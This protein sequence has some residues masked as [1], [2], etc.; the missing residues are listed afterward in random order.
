MTKCNEESWTGSWSRRTLV[1]NWWNVNK[2]CRLVI[3]VS[4]R[5]VIIVSML[6]SLF[7]GYVKF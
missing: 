7:Y 2:E 6:K 1:G 3:I 4:M 5:L